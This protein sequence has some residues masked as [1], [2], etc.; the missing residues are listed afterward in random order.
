MWVRTPFMARCKNDTTL[1]DKVWQW[2]ATGR[3]FSWVCWFPPPIINWLPQYSW[4]IL[5]SGVKHHKPNLQLNLFHIPFLVLKLYIF[6]CVFYELFP[7]LWVKWCNKV[8]Q[9]NCSFYQAINMFLK[10]QWKGQ[11]IWIYNFLSR[12]MKRTAWDRHKNVCVCGV[13]GG[14]VTS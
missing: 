12:A 11:R 10:E 14:G 13:G 2:L 8:L 3:W 1:S 7:L 5:D 6:M 9:S 4:N